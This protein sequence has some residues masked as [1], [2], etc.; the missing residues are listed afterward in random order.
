MEKDHSPLLIFQ[1]MRLRTIDLFSGLGG[2][3]YGLHD[4]CKTIAYCEL[5][6][7]CICTLKRNMKMRRIDTAP[8]IPD[9]R[10]FPHGPFCNV[11]L[12][13]MGF[14]CK[15]ISQC[16]KKK[17]LSVSN[18][19]RKR[20]AHVPSKEGRS[21]LFYAA[22]RVVE[23]YKPRYV[24]IENVANIVS[25]EFVWKSVIQSL[26]LNGYTSIR[27]CTVGACDVGAPHTRK[28]WFCLA[29]RSDVHWPTLGHIEHSSSTPHISVPW[30]STNLVFRSKVPWE[31]DIPR[32][33]AERSS[34]GKER[35]RQLGNMCVPQ[36][37]RFAFRVLSSHPL[38]TTK[39]SS[40]KPSR[41]ICNIQKLP[42]WGCIDSDDRVHARNSPITKQKVNLNLLLLP[43]RGIVRT[44]SRRTLPLL[45]AP[46]PKKLWATPRAGGLNQ[47]GSPGVG[48]LTTRTQHDL[49]TQMFHEANTR[50]QGRQENPDWVEW[51]MGLPIGWTTS[52]H[53]ES[54][55]K[56]GRIH[57]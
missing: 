15:D 43:S 14:P 23:S 49:S 2:I 28:R 41:Q 16:G 45:D 52:V 44:H 8:I 22:M 38:W 12:V 17:G 24:F 53:G 18:I 6:N 25:M 32:M 10:H 29:K 13:T 56:N 37:A 48:S 33:C 34:D 35:L 11:E 4:W 5:S 7:N 50:I 9:I 54:T 31:P 20:S 36:C 40:A 55:L 47:E 3:S 46:K 39:D 21:I 30:N 27:F 26:R 1:R 51:M 57:K 19:D 42:K